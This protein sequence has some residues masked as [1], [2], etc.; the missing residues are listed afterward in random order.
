VAGKGFPAPKVTPLFVQGAFGVLPSRQF[1]SQCREEVG[2]MQVEGDV[3]GGC[4]VLAGTGQAVR[5][6]PCLRRRRLIYLGPRSRSHGCSAS[7]SLK[8]YGNCASTTCT[9]RRRRQ[10]LW[11][12]TS[13][14][15]MA[16]VSGLVEGGPARY[17][18][19]L[20]DGAQGQQAGHEGV[21][22]NATEFGSWEMQAGSPGVFAFRLAFMGGGI[23]PPWLH[24]PPMLMRDSGRPVGPSNIRECQ[25][26]Q[27][28]R[29]WHPSCR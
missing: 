8:G 22:V 21:L 2:A 9:A 28:R 3:P 7:R 10:L 20:G 12:G 19:R 15:A 1:H 23:E 5:I 13:S 16:W 14:R 6:L 18:H 29:A 24:L 11:P 4:P 27:R 26:S 25:G 17:P